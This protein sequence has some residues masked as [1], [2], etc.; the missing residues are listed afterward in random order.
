M[1]I[2][3]PLQKGEVAAE[4]E[5]TGDGVLAEATREPR[6]GNARR[7]WAAAA[8][9]PTGDADAGKWVTASGGRGDGDDD[10]ERV[11][12]AAGQGAVAKCFPGAAAAAADNGTGLSA[13]SSPPE[14]RG[15]KVVSPST[16]TATDALLPQPLLACARYSPPPELPDDGVVDEREVV[17]GRWREVACCRIYRPGDATPPRQHPPPAL[18]RNGRAIK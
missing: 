2:P 3:P 5:S 10:D 17:L 12:A 14:G 1:T 4:G 13:M 8:G 7:S 11:A 16:P 9:T 15:K 6:L 18:Y